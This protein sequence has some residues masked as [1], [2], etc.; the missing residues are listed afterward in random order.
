MIFLKSISKEY[1]IPAS[2]PMIIVGKHEYG[3][4]Y[5]S[6]LVID[7][8]ISA[9]PTV[10][11]VYWTRNSSGI[12][13]TIDHGLSGTEGITVDNPSLTLLYI[14]DLDNGLY[15]CTAESYRGIGFSKTVNVTVNGGTSYYL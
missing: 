15:T 11:K 2:N 12:I 13:T 9:S 5:G 4:D 8:Q 10:L 14:T 1:F 7:T 3:P 6:K